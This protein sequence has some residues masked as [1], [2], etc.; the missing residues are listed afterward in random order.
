RFAH[1]LRPG[2]HQ[3]GLV[4]LTPQP[5]H[6]EHLLDGLLHGHILTPA[7]AFSNWYAVPP[8]I[9]KTCTFRPIS[10]KIRFILMESVSVRNIWPNSSAETS[11]ISLRVRL[12]SS[13]SKISSSSSSGLNPF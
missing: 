12:S 1:Q 6:I 8:M 11:C 13:L 3:R 2:V 7:H 10:A 5:V 9:A 4:K